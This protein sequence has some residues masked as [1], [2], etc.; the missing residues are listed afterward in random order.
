MRRPAA[1]AELEPPQRSHGPRL[2][3]IAL[4]AIAS[5]L[6]G[7]VGSGASPPPG[8]DSPPLETAGLDDLSACPNFRATI[9]SLPPPDISGENDPIV[10]EQQR[11][12]SDLEVV[13]AY[14][15]ANPLDF[16]SVRFENLPRVRIVVGFRADVGKHC[17]ALRAMLA[18]PDSF[19]ITWQSL[20]EIELTELHERIVMEIRGDMVSVGQASDHLEVTLRADAVDTA[21]ALLA[22]YGSA[23]RLTV[24]M[25]PFPDPGGAAG[26]RCLLPDDLRSA[27]V[28][29][30]LEL[31]PAIVR[32]GADFRGT[33]RL[34]NPGA[35]VL[36]VD[37]G[38][39]GIAY[40]YRLGEDRPI[41][42]YTGI[43]G[44][45]GRGDT[46][47]PG[48]SLAIGVVGGTASCD[49]ASGWALGPGP[50]E[51][52]ALIEWHTDAGIG[53]LLSNPADLMIVP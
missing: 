12:R 37:S 45:V 36:V 42:T 49:P 11:L 38:E 7:C 27:D 15:A 3:A 25:L 8:D 21:R 43:I 4:V 18:F 32:S 19:E 23:V 10:I 53:H 39:P 33:V 34:T 46:L 40:I 47:Q 5:L 6:A 50:Y 51:A 35:G 52:R 13:Q 1:V 48:A 17:A 41:G 16:G 26:G 14:A 22:R 29:T 31:E 9:E 30:R 20:S 44:G 28:Q 24:G 2:S